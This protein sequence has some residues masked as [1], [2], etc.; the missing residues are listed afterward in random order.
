M[1]QIGELDCRKLH[2]VIG[3]SSL[4]G[5]VARLH[6]P[7]KLI[8]ARAAVEETEIYFVISKTLPI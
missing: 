8:L 2:K 1:G 6:Q 3:H 7:V 5:D 4:L